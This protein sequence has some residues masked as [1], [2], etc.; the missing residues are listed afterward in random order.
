MFPYYCLIASGVGLVGHFLTLD[1]IS[2]QEN[3]NVLNKPCSVPQNFVAE[4][5]HRVST[6]LCGFKFDTCSLS[7][8]EV[9]AACGISLSSN[10]AGACWQCFCLHVYALPLPKTISMSVKSSC[11]NLS[12]QGPPKSWWCWKRARHSGMVPMEGDANWKRQAHLTWKIKLV[13]MHTRICMWQS[14]KV[15]SRPL[16]V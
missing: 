10:V 16:K 6:P 12:I 2:L 15:S 13:P 3:K 8:E 4:C 5:A 7:G 14:A 1:V 9:M 11:C